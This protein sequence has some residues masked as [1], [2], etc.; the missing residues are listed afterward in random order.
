MAVRS[1][2]GHIVP[3]EDPLGRRLYWLSVRAIEQAEEG[4]DLWAVRQQY[5]SLTPL[6]LDLTDHAALEE[7]RAKWSKQ[8]A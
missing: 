2:D 8:T 5:V 6:R 1:Y 4:T 7:A 3:A